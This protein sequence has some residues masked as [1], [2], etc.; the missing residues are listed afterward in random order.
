MRRWSPLPGLLLVVLAGC[1]KA[2]GKSRNTEPR[3]VEAAGT[4]AAAPAASP[5]DEL[6][7]EPAL[8]ARKPAP[9]M[10]GARDP[11]PPPTPAAA[12]DPSAPA[13]TPPP[14][15]PTGEEPAPLVPG[16][17]V[18]GPPAAPDAPV[19][20]VPPGDTPV[21]LLEVPGMDETPPN[22]PPPAAE[23]AATPEILAGG[24]VTLN[25]F[26]ICKDVR[27]REPVGPASSFARERE[28]QV[29]VYLDAANGGSEPQPVTVNFESVDRPGSAPPAVALEIGPG[30]RYRTWARASTWRPA[31]TYRVVVRDV[32]G[33]PL[34]RGT[35]Q[36]VEL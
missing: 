3:L 26:V 1:S 20:N 35:F 32:A 24:A 30:P 29:W 27:D 11:L 12:A 23:P 16:A 34:A 31:G 9:P 28:G 17:P 8:G 6:G 22:A 4:V 33:T 15:L 21:G 13:G 14:P 25:R 19:P 5:T 18:P 10:P 2:P 36:I 7:T